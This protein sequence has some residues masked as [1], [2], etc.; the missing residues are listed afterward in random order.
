MEA[1]KVEERNAFDI[2]VDYPLKHG[3]EF[4]T[5][6]D[7]RRFFLFPT[8]SILNSK[9]VIFKYGS[10]YLY[11]YDSYTARMYMSDTTTGIY[12]ISNVAE[13][14]ELKIHKKDFTDLLLRINKKKTGVR[15]IDD[16]LTITSNKD[17]TLSIPKEAVSLFQEMAKRFSPFHLVIE[18]NY[19][20]NIGEL[21]DKKVIGLETQQWLHKEE[22]V[23][24]FLRL[25]EELLEHFKNV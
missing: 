14:V 24:L 15:Y 7:Y 11:A 5:H 19:I 17:L 22:D 25:G 16:Y 13:D 12:G 8:D 20:Q 23:D 18:N 10:L 3:L 1:Q 6:L 21:K 4:D 9:F 2:L